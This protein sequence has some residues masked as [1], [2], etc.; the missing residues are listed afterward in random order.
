MPAV[1]AT[2]G[3]T[4]HGT[5]TAA[6]A[7]VVTVPPADWVEVKNRGTADL[8]CQTGVSDLT[9]GAVGTQIVP[10]GE[11]LPLSLPVAIGR[12]GNSIICLKS[13][14]A[15]A[16][17]V[18]TVTGSTPA[19]R[20][21]GGGGAA[22]GTADTELPAAAALSDTAANPTTPMIGAAVLYWDGTQWVRW[23]RSTKELTVAAATLA[24]VSAATSSTALFA[25]NANVRGRIVHNDSTGILYLK[26]GTGASTTSYTV[27]IPPDG[28]FE[29]PKPTYTGDVAGIWS[30]ANGSARTTEV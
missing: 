22:G 7:E 5:T 8:W 1:D 12:A 2:S 24:N 18:R 23:Q 17:S 19:N 20:S 16:Y 28:F 21:G 3:G 6:T 10:A 13:A 14:G 30:A 15:V 27:K 11:A 26:F 4:A 25:S 9:I 29:F